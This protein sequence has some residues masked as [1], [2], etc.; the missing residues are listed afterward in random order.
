M[1]KPIFNSLGSNYPEEFIESGAAFQSDPTRNQEELSQQL[2]ERLQNHFDGDVILTYKGRDAIELVLRPIAEQT[3][4]G[5]VL[6]QG[7]ACHA[8]EEGILRA[9]LT[10]IYVDIAEGTLGPSLQTLEAGLHRAKELNVEPKV[11]FLQHLLGYANSVEEIRAFCTKQKLL[12]IEDL[13]QSFG[14]SDRDELELG[15][16]SDAVICSFGRDKVIDAVSGGAVVYTQAYWEKLGADARH[17]LTKL[18]PSEFPPMDVVKKELAY[19]GLTAMIQKTHQL[20]LGR[21]IFKLAKLTGRLTSPIA[22]A[23]QHPTRLPAGYVQ[24]ALWQL[25]HLEEQLTHRRQLAL[26]YHEALQSIPGVSCFIRKE[27]L[28]QD[29]HLRVPV[30]FDST[31]QLQQTLAALAARE[32]HLTDRWYR[33]VVDS[34]SLNYPSLYQAGQCPVAEFTADRLLNLPTHGKISV[35]DAERI[36][37][38]IQESIVS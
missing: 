8:I 38:A 2:R 12:L 9:G 23:V 37:Q 20:G 35:A 17:W 25:D 10:P 21:L 33:K 16:S 6:T 15:L 36:V 3:P 5:G 30:L 27:Q 34:G 14:A 4:Q 7:L 1:A 11:V 31:G 26:I 28:Q 24:L 13:A 29:I 32:I 22:T 18:Q 19:P